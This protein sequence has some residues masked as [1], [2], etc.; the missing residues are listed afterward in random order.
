MPDELYYALQEI[1]KYSGVPGILFF[2]LFMKEKSTITRIVFFI[3][4]ASFI[5]DFSNYF[6]MK[7][8]YKNGFVITNSWHIINFL[9]VS[10]YFY[11]LMPKW[12]SLVLIM[13]GIF[14]L[15]AIGSFSFFY[16]FLQPNT[17]IRALSSISFSIVSILC[18]FE[19]LRQSPTDD[20]S[21]YPVF[22]IVSAIFLYSSTTLF[23]NLFQNYFL[24]SLGGVGPVGRWVSLFNMTFNIAKNL[25]FLYAF[26]LVHKGY[27]DY[28]YQ[29]KPIPND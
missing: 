5:A 3:L 4:L 7:Y 17:F 21:R 6:F 24:Q 29:P 27:P 11:Q 20:L 18:L 12:R 28:I 14:I 23:R 2:M 8:V 10:W 22:W 19:I 16:S 26:S 9:F 25:M 1:S 15:T 13:L